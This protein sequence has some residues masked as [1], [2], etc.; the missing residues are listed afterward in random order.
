MVR[1]ALEAGIKASYLLVDTWFTNEP[2]IKTM[3]GGDVGIDVIGMLKD[4]KQ[5]YWYKGRLLK[6]KSLASMVRFSSTQNIFG[7]VCVQTK[8]HK[9]PVKIVFVRNRNKHGEYILILST[10]C[11]LSDEEI[12]RLYGIWSIE[13]CFK[14]C[15]SLLKLGKEFQG[16]SYDMTVST[17]AVVF[18]R[19]IILEWLRRK[20]N[21]QKTMCEL[22]FVCCEDIQDLEL[23]EALAQLLDLFV[24]G[25]N[26]GSLVVTESFRLKL[27]GWFVS[28]PEFIRILYPEFLSGLQEIKNIS[29]TCQVA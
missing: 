23:N 25:M 24:S 17:T 9:I 14:A 19:F 7:S 6:L 1:E 27:V 15:K 2:F 29:S 21:D 10:D 22:F 4:T 28:Q 18:T 3:T 12:V 26:D 5:Q 13:C 20:E 11:S 8:N 16:I